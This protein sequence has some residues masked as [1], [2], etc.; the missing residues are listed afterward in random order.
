MFIKPIKAELLY[1]NEQRNESYLINPYDAKAV[2]VLS[3]FQSRRDIDIICASMGPESSVCVLH[4]A[5]AA[6]INSAY[7]LS[8]KA[9]AGADTVATSYVL[10]KAFKKIGADVII[11]GEKATDG[12]TGQTS[13]GVAQRLNYKFISGVEEILEIDG[14]VLTI[15]CKTQDRM[16]MIRTDAPV[17]LI[18][19]GLTT[20]QSI[21]SLI[22]L[23]RARSKGV[24]I[25]KADDIEA[26]V[27]LCGI[28]GSRTKVLSIKDDLLKKDGQTVIATPKEAVSMILGVMKNR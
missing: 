6:G 23:K 26:D 8:D 7:L 9:F 27:S 17:I 12:E 4:R 28:K 18:F 14:N 13:F 25:L 15:K 20:K 19:S 16:R 1:P 10:E 3:A 22:G 24:T 2:G 5:L 21:C 11:M